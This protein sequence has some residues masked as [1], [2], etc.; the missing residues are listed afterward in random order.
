MLWALSTLGLGVGAPVTLLSALEGEAPGPG[1]PQVSPA[2]LS[3]VAPGPPRRGRDRAHIVPSGVSEDTAEGDGGRKSS[4]GPSIEEIIRA[5]A[6]DRGLEG[7]YLVSIAVCE[8]GLDPRAYNAAGYHGL[9]Q[10]DEQTWAA[11][12]RGSIW[13]PVAQARTT[14]KLIAEGQSSRWPNCA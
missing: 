12:G 7:D 10:Y 13:D 4:G 2:T 9:F 3:L 14:A 1:R 11:Y 6:R 8:S 5:A